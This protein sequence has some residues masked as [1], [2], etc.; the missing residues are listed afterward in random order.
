MSKGEGPIHVRVSEVRK[1]AH[2]GR[3]SVGIAVRI[4]DSEGKSVH[5][6]GAVVGHGGAPLTPVPHEEQG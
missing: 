3:K 5:P 1:E 6:S 4:E 2:L